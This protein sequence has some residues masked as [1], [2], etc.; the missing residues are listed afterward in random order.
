MNRQKGFSAFEAL[1]I[2]LILI[3]LI[4]L[5]WFVWDK[6][7]DKDSSTNTANNSQEADVAPALKEYKNTDKIGLSFMYPETWNVTEAMVET[8]LGLDGEVTVEHPDGLIVSIK[9]NYGGKGFGC[10]EDAGDTPHKTKNCYTEEMLKKEKTLTK[11]NYPA[12]D[13]DVY[14][15]RTKFTTGQNTG[16]KT[17]YNLILSNNTEETGANAPLV[18]A[19]ADLGLIVRDTQNKP[20]YI[21]TTLK[22]IDRSDPNLFDEDAVKEAEDIL[23]SLKLF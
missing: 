11:A 5:G 2:L 3:L 16:A 14:L 1:I 10:D 18:G 15:L 7:K 4:L 9:F 13:N 22:G 19:W 8:D 23:R 17:T 21:E 12:L 20:P 6:Q